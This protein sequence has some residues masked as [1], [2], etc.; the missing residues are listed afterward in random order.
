MQTRR[1]AT[2]A[3]LLIR[4]DLARRFAD[5]PDLE[6]ILGELEKISTGADWFRQW[7]DLFVRR[8]NATLTAPELDALGS[9]DSVIGWT[10]ANVAR[11]MNLT[12]ADVARLRARLSG[13]PGTVRW[14]I[15][16]V[17]GAFPS[18]ENFSTLLQLLDDPSDQLVQYGALRSLA[19]MAARSSRSDLREA[20]VTA[21]LARTL[22]S[23]PV[24]YEGSSDPVF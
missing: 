4:S 13:A 7:R 10:A 16:H 6:T 18:P 20:I 11:R 19:E 14:R 3:L 5:A 12:E 23:H 1:R 21:L 2:D 24:V 8:S 15:A 17:L 9:D 22:M